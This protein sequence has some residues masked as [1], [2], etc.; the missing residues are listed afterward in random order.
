MA[1]LLT[2]GDEL[3]LHLTTLEELASIHGDIRA[4]LSSV[5]SVEVLEDAHEPADA[6]FKVIGGRLPG[7]FEIGTFSASGHRIFAAVHHDTPRG[8]LITFEG[9]HHAA[10]IVGCA[11]PEAVRRH[12]TGG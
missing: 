9:A 12:I 5:T 6:G 8:L 7:N 4:P 2:E 11:D 3:V 10:W 1:E